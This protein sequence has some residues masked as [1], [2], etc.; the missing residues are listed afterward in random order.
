[1]RGVTRP[2][3]DVERVAYLLRLGLPQAEVARRTGVP[4]STVQTWIR[5]DPVATLA[6]RLAVPVHAHDGEGCGR[7][8]TVPRPA[9][10][11]LLGLYLGDGCLSGD[12]KDVYRLRVVL[13]VRYPMIVAECAAAMS[14]VLPNK[15]GLIN[16]PGCV[17]VNAYSKHWPCLFPQHGPGPKHLRPIVLRPWQEEIAL[18]D[19]PELFLRGLVHSDGYRGMNRIKGGY[20]YPRYLFDNRSDDIRALFLEGCRRVGVHAGQSNRWTIS[21]ARK[22]DVALMDTFI[23]PKT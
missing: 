16:N 13:D 20:A 4:R 15:V 3:C 17:A 22:A 19:H 1:M 21:V 5:N 7:V 2:A 9:Y 11:Y 10:A 12:E 14:E 6:R 8:R 18:D 23:G